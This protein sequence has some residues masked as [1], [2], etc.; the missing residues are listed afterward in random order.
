MS[1]DDTVSGKLSSAASQ[2]QTAI[3]NAR[4]YV[5][6]A[7]LDSLKEKA[8][9]AASAVYQQGRDLANSDRVVN[10]TEQIASSIRKNPLA[11][12]GLAF[13]AGLVLALLTRG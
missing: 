9:D 8:S 6:D 2:A 5:A 1:N 12:V 11:A 4:Q 13:T 10:A 3:D 7:D